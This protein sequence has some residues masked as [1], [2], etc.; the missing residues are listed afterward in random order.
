MYQEEGVEILER[1]IEDY[2]VDE[3]PDLVKEL[4]AHAQEYMNL[5]GDPLNRTAES[6]THWADGKVIRSLVLPLA[7]F[8]NEFDEV[9]FGIG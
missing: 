8:M 3:S 7:Q 5:A 1:I 2:L 4:S 9:V 6:E